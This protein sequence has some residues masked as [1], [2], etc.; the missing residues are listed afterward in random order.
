M[1]ESPFYE[2]VVFNLR[3]IKEAYFL[4]NNQKIYDGLKRFQ[5]EKQYSNR[6]H[7]RTQKGGGQCLN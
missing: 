6:C 3:E 4:V 5:Q 2:K 7:Y 1:L